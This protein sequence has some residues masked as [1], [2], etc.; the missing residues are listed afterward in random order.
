M[1]R[2]LIFWLSLGGL[3]LGFLVAAGAQDKST[4]DPQ[5]EKVYAARCAD[6]HRRHGQGLPNIFPALANNSFVTG[7]PLGV[8]QVILAGRRGS[9]GRMP[10][11]Q[12]ILN[13]QEIAAVVTYIRQ[14]WGNQA[15]AVT[16]EQV[17]AQRR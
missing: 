5:G 17:A 11:W 16:P 3:L 6:C 2:N 8:I 4:P 7:D 1:L 13:D 9:M 10:A 15:E 14:A 12:A